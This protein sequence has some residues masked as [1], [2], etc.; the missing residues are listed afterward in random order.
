M[1]RPYRALLVDLDGT[2][3]DSRAPTER[4]W[5]EWA[6]GRGLADRADEVARTC[7][8]V[9][10]AQ[11]VAAWAPE[12]DAQAEADR[13]EAAQIASAEPVSAFPRAADLLGLLPPGGVAVVTSGTRALA[14]GRLAQAGLPEPAVMVCA[15]DV[16]RG[17]PG[18]D[19]FLFAA[20]RLGVAPAECLVVEDAPAG[21]AAG[22]AAGCQ[23]VAVAQTHGCAQ[24]DGAT[25]CLPDLRVA[26]QVLRALRVAA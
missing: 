17:K 6:A 19:P 14:T 1:L 22:L 21:V 8:G 26:V 10:T 24:L 13:I 12:L 15:G 25:A 5:R 7:H 2:L 16:A 3:V 23:V 9:P 20:S 18:P 4:A 11:H